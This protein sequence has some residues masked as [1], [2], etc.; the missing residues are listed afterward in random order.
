VM[1]GDAYWKPLCDLACRLRCWCR[2]AVRDESGAWVTDWGM[3]LGIPA[4]GYLE[5]PGGPVPIPCV[6][7]VEISTSKLKGGLAGRPL[8]RIVVTDEVLSSLREVPAAWEL[9]LTTWS[10][11]GI[12]SLE[13]VEAVH[14]PNPFGPTQCNVSPH[15]GRQGWSLQLA[16]DAIRDG[17]G[18]EL[19]DAKR[20]IRAEVFRCD[21][22]HTV[23]VTHVGKPAPPEILDWY[24]AAAARR[25]DPFED[26]SALLERAAWRGV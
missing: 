5:G 25:L 10:V 8:E 14:L 21:A 15:P 24:Y 22:D 16:S 17:L 2:M 4:P 19:L 23:T 9:R 6:E 26:G 11:Q 13:P 20:M 3:G 12:L 1:P 18:M 7:W